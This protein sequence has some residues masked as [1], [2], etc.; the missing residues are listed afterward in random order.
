MIQILMSIHTEFSC[1]ISTRCLGFHYREYTCN[2]LFRN[3]K[4]IEDGMTTY[5]DVTK[6]TCAARCGLSSSC[7][8]FFYSKVSKK[9][10]VGSLFGDVTLVSEEGWSAYSLTKGWQ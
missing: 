6:V 3:K 10:L 5:S 7:G 1:Y 9:C 8:F 4:T 2:L